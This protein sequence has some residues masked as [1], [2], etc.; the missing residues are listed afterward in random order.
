MKGDR[1]T[2]ISYMLIDDKEA[3]HFHPKIISGI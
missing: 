1:V 2:I 3:K